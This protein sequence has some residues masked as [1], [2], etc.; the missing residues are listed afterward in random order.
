MNNESNEGIVTKPNSKEFVFVRF[1]VNYEKYQLLQ[2]IDVEL[3]K[4]NIYFVPY[5]NVK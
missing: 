5:D 3:K 1:L 4:D 2:D